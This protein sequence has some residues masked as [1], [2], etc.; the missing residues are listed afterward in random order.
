MGTRL[1]ARGNTYY[2]Y[3]TFLKQ[4]KEEAR[5]AFLNRFTA[6]RHCRRLGETGDVVATGVFI[7][8]DGILVKVSGTFYVNMVD[9]QWIIKENRVVPELTGSIVDEKVQVRVGPVNYDVR[10]GMLEIPDP[11]I[12]QAKFYT[13]DTRHATAT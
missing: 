2:K 11:R 12:P 3:V 6:G 10:M 4:A 7:K 8:G 1:G 5:Q 9:L 13:S